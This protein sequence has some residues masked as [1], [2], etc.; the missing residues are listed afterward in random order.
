MYVVIFSP[1]LFSVH[2][3]YKFTLYYVIVSKEILYM[4]IYQVFLA[5]TNDYMV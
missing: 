3:T 4:D 5:N 2:F 1:E